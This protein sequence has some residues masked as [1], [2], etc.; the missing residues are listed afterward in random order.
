MSILTI[1]LY[2]YKTFQRLVAMSG[3]SLRNLFAMLILLE[4]YTY[5]VHTRHNLPSLY[6]LCRGTIH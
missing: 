4:M 6:R 1:L 3:E 5:T 2:L